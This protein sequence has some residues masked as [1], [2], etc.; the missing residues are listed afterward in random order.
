MKRMKL[1]MTSVSLGLLVFL[2]GCGDE[3]GLSWTSWQMQKILENTV[4]LA[5]RANQKGIEFYKRE[6]WNKELDYR[7][8]VMWFERAA[9]YGYA[10]AQNNLGLCHARGHGVKQ[11]YAKAVN[12]FRKA[13]EQGHAA[14]QN[15][16]GICYYNGQGV[17]HSYED[18]VKWFRKAAE[19]GNADAMEALAAC[20]EK[21]LGVPKSLEEAAAWRAKAEDQK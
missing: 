20:Y 9:Q 2:T 15:D 18:A 11:S 14:A 10:D 8:S 7:L 16:L 12:W 6:S 1:F 5:P 3:G 13:A 4:E 17:K 21:G 19:Q